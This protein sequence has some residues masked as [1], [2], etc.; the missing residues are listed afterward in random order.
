MTAPTA[1]A[2]HP[3][4]HGGHGHGLDLARQSHRRRLLWVLVL[5]LFF[6]IAELTGGWLTGS[7]ALLADAFHLVSDVAA[8]AIS[9]FAAWVTVRPSSGRRT[10]GHS[11]A[12]IL[13]ALANGVGLAVVACL[14]SYHAIGRFG[15]PR[16]VDGL[17]VVAFAT[18]ALLY[19]GVSLWILHGAAG[20]NLNVR[21]AF[22]HV[23]SD[24]LGSVGAILAGLAI[25][26]YG[27]N[28]AD[29]VASLLI[30]ALV[31]HAAWSLVRDALDV[32]METAPSHLDVAEIRDTMNAVPEVSSVHDLHVWTVGSGEICL[33]S[34]VVVPSP[35]S[36][37]RILD[38]IRKLL[39]ERFAI[40]HTTI[41]IEV[42]G[43]ARDG[44]TALGPDCEGACPD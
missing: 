39:R 10:F 40:T 8:L 27:W 5:A 9:L 17:G 18:A 36:E 13:A 28:W 11:R 31:L 19:E 22:L 26:A 41:Q 35:G 34:H 15:T 3:H 37:P 20:D 12:E 29:P 16:E 14:I 42:P 1:E 21:G 38:Q 2:S 30:S 33:S 25:W 24:A 32:L 44:V 7:L 6:S 23:L 43:R 4:A